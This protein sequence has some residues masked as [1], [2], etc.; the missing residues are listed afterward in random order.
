MI[1]LKQIRYALA[2]ERTLHFKRAAEECHISQSEIAVWRKP[3]KH[4][5]ESS[6]E[7]AAQG[8]GQINGAVAESMGE[9]PVQEQRQ[10]AVLDEVHGL[11][12][13]RPEARCG[14]HEDS[15]HS[16]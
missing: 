12:R 13:V 1:S 16:Q 15:R 7:D 11:L 9:G 6:N 2:V 5:F 14:G 8:R 10:H 4:L 3:L